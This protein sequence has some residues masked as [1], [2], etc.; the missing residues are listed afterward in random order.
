MTP[1]EIL[2]QIKRFD[3]NMSREQ[4]QRYVELEKALTPPTVD[5]VCNALSKEIAMNE[6]GKENRK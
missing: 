6:L 5:E 3:Y 1:L 2:K 4:N